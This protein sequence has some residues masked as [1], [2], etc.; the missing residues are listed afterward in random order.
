MMPI[1][2]SNIAILIINGVHKHYVI[3]EISKHEPI[4]SLWNVDFTEKSKIL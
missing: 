2:L 3:S 4:N 1:N